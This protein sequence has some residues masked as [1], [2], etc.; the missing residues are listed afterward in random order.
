METV[1]LCVMV[2]FL[3][4]TTAELGEMR[5]SRV[6]KTKCC[7]FLFRMATMNRTTCYAQQRR[8]TRVMT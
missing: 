6:L 3:R 8:S 7:S 5:Y 1:D 4:E 2:L